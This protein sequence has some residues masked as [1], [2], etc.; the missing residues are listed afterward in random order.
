MIVVDDSFHFGRPASRYRG[1]HSRPL[2][3]R[4]RSHAELASVAVVFAYVLVRLI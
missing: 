1:E 3:R 2:D 4:A